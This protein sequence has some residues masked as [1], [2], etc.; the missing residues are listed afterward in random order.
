MSLINEA[1]KRA[2]LEAARQDA[3]KKGYVLNSD[4]SLRRWRHSGGKSGR[5][6]LRVGMITLVLAIAGIAL[7]YFAAKRSRSKQLT[8]GLTTT[9]APATRL[10]PSSDS[11]HQTVEAKLPSH[12]RV[13][14]GEGAMEANQEQPPSLTNDVTN[15][16]PSRSAPIDAATI[17]G[18]A[19]TE[20]GSVTPQELSSNTALRES[21]VKTAPVLDRSTPD[22]EPKNRA[23]KETPT[24]ESY[25]REFTLRD[26]TRV[27]LG[28]IAW[29]ESG[30]YALVNGRVVGV[31]EFVGDLVI[32]SIHPNHIQLKGRN[33]HVLLELR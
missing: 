21:P 24:T 32:E 11:P 19:E 6:W 22:I 17:D 16:R 31:G 15:L 3:T 2:R 13:A 9:V 20:F 10:D 18:A 23:T 7:F 14:R 33:R 29:S 5:K 12:V 4:Q 27:E 28:G 30:P 8:V 1:L 26:G 25:E